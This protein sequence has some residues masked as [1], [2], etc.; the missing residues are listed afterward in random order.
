MTD[1]AAAPSS[2]TR[3]IG[4]LGVAAIVVVVMGVPAFLDQGVPLRRKFDERPL[5]AL[6]KARVEG[7][8]IG[9][10]ML[11]SR[12]D[13]QKLKGLAG[14][15]WEVLAQPGGSSAVWYLMMKNLIAV[16]SPPPKTVII[17][18]RDRQLTLPAH[19]TDTGYRKTIEGYM[20]ADEPKVDALLRAGTHDRQSGLEWVAQKAY[21]VQWRRDAWQEKVQS[22]A[23]DLIASSGDY[24]KIREDT[25]AV[26][27]LQNLR[28]DSGMDF[29]REEGGQR[30]LNPDEHEF[31]ASVDASFLP[32]IIEIAREK[33]IQLIFFRVKRKPVSATELAKEGLTYAAYLEALR[34]YLEKAGAKFVDETR[35]PEVTLKYYGADDHVAPS[36][37]KAYTELFWRKMSPH[38]APAEG[39]EPAR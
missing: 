22:W 38:V 7:V 6:E 31:G 36:Q 1:P 39:A 27:G 33:G 3:S 15:R 8:L 18:F 21:P 9:D 26:F 35:D 29:E 28:Q 4:W 19:R 12:I 24:G 20:R 11:E 25:Q 30:G 32:A 10:S 23:L 37:M 14:K 16:Q 5:R 34:A 2:R 17:F 13:P